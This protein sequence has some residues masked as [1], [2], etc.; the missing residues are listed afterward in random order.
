MKQSGSARPTVEF[1]YCLS[2]PWTYLAFLRLAETALRTAALIA[3]RPILA[4]WLGPPSER[5]LPY[6][7][8][9]PD[10][11][12]RAYAAKDLADWARFCSVTIRLPQPWPVHPELAQ[13]GAVL[14]AEAGL[15][16]PYLD[17][18]FRAHF[19][20]GRNIAERAVVLE[21]AAGCGLSGAAFE[22]GLTSESTLAALRH[23]TEELRARKGFGSP[24]MFLGSDFY[25]GHDRMPLLEVALMRAAERPFLAPGEHGRL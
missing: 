23:N 6:A 9:G 3:Y 18:M 5:A 12:V 14:A 21:V 11:N 13:R 7:W 20:A 4:H 1:F 19:A 2:C 10:P 24:M 8:L 22:A 16:R 25:F 17:A 15:A